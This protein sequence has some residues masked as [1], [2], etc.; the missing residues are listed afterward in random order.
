MTPLTYI[1]TGKPREDTCSMVPRKRTREEAELP[2][3]G[4]TTSDKSKLYSL[5]PTP[6][7]ILFQQ[8]AKRSKTVRSGLSQQNHTEASP[9]YRYF[10]AP[11]P[12]K[13]LISEAR[14]A[15]KQSPSGDYF[16][17]SHA[18]MPM[19]T[20]SSARMEDVPLSLIQGLPLIMPNFLRTCVPETFSTCNLT[21]CSTKEVMKKLQELPS[22]QR[23]PTP[24]A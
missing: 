1:F 5:Q 20:G 12:K 6:S 17:N 19:P 21:T 14:L 22:G 8:I 23:P 18:S 2:S 3:G 9:Q 4:T 13:L 11:A 15:S 7:F 10:N 16:L 24:Y